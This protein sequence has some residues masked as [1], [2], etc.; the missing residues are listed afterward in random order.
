MN[1]IIHYVTMDGVKMDRGVHEA[2]LEATQ[3]RVSK[4]DTKKIFAK[5]ADGGKATDIEHKTVKTH[6][7][8]KSALNYYTSSI[9]ALKFGK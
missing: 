9:S 7:W 5:V 4:E 6:D 2:I 3:G 1:P 8:T